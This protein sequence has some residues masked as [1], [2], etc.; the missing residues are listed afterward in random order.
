MHYIVFLC[1]KSPS[2][3]SLDKVWVELVVPSA[4]ERGGDVESLAVEG[5]L[6]H[7]W[8]SMDLLA[9]DEDWG[10]LGGEFRLFSDLHCTI[11]ADAA[12]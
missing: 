3:P 4:V 10:W 12:S 5:Q 6:Q 11:T 2:V 1:A 9:V 7:L 8:S